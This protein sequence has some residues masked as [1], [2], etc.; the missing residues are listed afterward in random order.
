MLIAV[1]CEECETR[2]ELVR[3]VYAPERIYLVCRGCEMSIE[4]DVT[5]DFL[6]REFNV[7]VSR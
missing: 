3:R 2:N 6:Q 1:T 4:T 7:R 5:A